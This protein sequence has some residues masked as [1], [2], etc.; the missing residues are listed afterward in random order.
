MDFGLVLQTDPPASG[1]V[2][3]MRRAER[4]G[5]THGWTFDSAVLWQ[6]PFV[7]Y[8]RILEHTRKLIVG[9]MVTNPGT[10]TWEVT[11]STFA[12]LNSMYGNRTVCGI[13]RGDSAMRVAGRKPN[14]LARVGEAM[15]VIRDLAEGREAS[16]DGTP[17]RLPWVENGKLPV[18]MAAYGPKALALAGEKADGFIL[19]LADPFLTE[20][21]IH[22]VREAAS[23]AG[24]DPSEITICVAAPAYVTDG[25]DEQLAHAREQCRWFGGMVGNHVADLVSR[26]GE[27]SGLVPDELTAYIKQRQGYDYAHHGRS[28][29]P[30]TA[31][32]PD[33]IVDRFCLLGPVEAHLAKL[34][35]LRGLGVDQFAL[36]DMHDAKESTIDAY[37]E[38]IIPALS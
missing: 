38:H 34:E 26:Y 22:A 1:V 21:M 5:F 19:Q 32:V 37:G 13:G 14:T 18:W 27:H 6:E 28:G 36:Y 9:P 15:G 23:A 12:T 4:N 16:V 25:S 30:D 35:H 24:R 11:A 17:M 33:E 7:I 10:R 2:G 31:F 3:L 29:N 8:S 20:W